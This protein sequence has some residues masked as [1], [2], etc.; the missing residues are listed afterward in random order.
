MPKVDAPKRSK[1]PILNNPLAPE[2]YA[3]NVLGYYLV[4]NTMRFTFTT[5]RFDH[6]TN[7]GIPSR[8]VT[9]RLVIPIAEAENFRKLLTAIIDNTKSQ[10]QEPGIGNNTLQ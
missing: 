8:V 5:T 4:N 3:D 2:M 9:G 6:L 7:P 10:S 1:L